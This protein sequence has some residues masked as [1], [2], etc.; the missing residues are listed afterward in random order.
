MQFLFH[1]MDSFSIVSFCHVAPPPTKKAHC[2]V[3]VA[4]VRVPK[5]LPALRIHNFVGLSGQNLLIPK[6]TMSVVGFFRLFFLK[7]KRFCCEL[8]HAD[9]IQYL[10]MWLLLG[11]SEEKLGDI[12]PPLSHDQVS[13]PEIAWNTFENCKKLQQVHLT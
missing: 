9:I 5:Q 2:L 1:P 11:A 12:C 6:G 10:Y 7:E 13:G 8:L 3:N 4:E